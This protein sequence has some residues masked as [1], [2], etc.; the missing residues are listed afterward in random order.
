MNQICKTNQIGAFLLL[1][2]WYGMRLEARGAAADSI[3]TIPIAAVSG[4]Q[5][6]VVRF[7]VKPGETV[8]LSLENKDDMAHNLVI[9]S[10]DAREAV[11]KAAQALGAKGPS[12][13]FIP[14]AD[15]VLWTI[16]VTYPGE[17]KSVT[18]QAPAKTGAYPY[19]CTYPGHGFL[20]YGV[21]YVGNDDEALP[22][23]ATDPHV[24]EARRQK[25]QPARLHPY[26]ISPPYWYRGF[27]EETSL[28]SIAVHLPNQLS[29]CW[30]TELCQLR[31]AWEGE[32]LDNS[33][34]WH[35]HKNAYA[36]ILGTIFFRDQVISPIRF[37]D[38]ET[39]PSV[40]YK[41]YNIRNRYPEFH[42]TV[43]GK[44][45]Y[46]LI[47]EHPEKKGLIR[48][49]RIPGATE[50]VWFL[51]GDASGVTYRFSAGVTQNGKVKLTAAEA[52]NFTIQMIKKEKP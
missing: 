11:V 35:G 44:D 21:M 8:T 29:Y 23:L 15:Y 39:A 40:V 41:G 3:R 1:V 30:D 26:E 5:Y 31:Y 33:D 43:A 37:M 25:Q 47:K 4:M 19:V 34:L 45:V 17:K 42:Y 51:F 22:D 9:T 46:E 7:R 16:P 6:D 32:F 13:D 52:R 10:P 28:A 49:I 48:T 36:K 12:Q 50:P 27:L 24:P 14:E 20:M 18:F 2:A 38:A